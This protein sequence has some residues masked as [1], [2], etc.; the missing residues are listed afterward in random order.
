[1]QTTLQFEGK[2]DSYM[3]H[4]WDQDLF[5][6]V[7]MAR[8]VFDVIRTLPKWVGPR[9]K[10]K[11]KRTG[12][13]LRDLAQQIERVTDTYIANPPATPILR[14]VTQPLD[15]IRPPRVDADAERRRRAA[16]DAERLHRPFGR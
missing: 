8:I 3:I 5:L 16:Q 12:D 15:T 1:M 14:R 9:V 6:P 4:L 2:G 13:P 11:K 10:R 7:R